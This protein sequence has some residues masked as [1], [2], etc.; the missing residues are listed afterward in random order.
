MIVIVIVHK[1][2]SFRKL[3]DDVSD[4]WRGRGRRQCY[5]QGGRQENR[6]IRNEFSKQRVGRETGGGGDRVAKVCPTVFAGARGRVGP[7]GGYGRPCD[8]GSGP[9]LPGR[10]FVDWKLM[11]EGLVMGEEAFV[12]GES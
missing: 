2:L 9:E 3:A 8:A 10:G 11:D 12:E 6:L 5:V 4:A 1:S 7:R